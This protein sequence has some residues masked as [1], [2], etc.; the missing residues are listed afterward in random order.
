LYANYECNLIEQAEKN[1]LYISIEVYR[2]PTTAAD[3]L[4]KKNHSFQQ[5]NQEVLRLFTS[6]TLKIVISYKFTDI[7]SKCKYKNHNFET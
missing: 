7:F 6:K 1:I 2:R 3:F 4:K 5:A